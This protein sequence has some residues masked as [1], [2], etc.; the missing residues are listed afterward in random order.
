MMVDVDAGRFDETDFMC[1]PAFEFNR[2]H[3]LHQ[4][5]IARELVTFNMIWGSLES[6]AKLAKAPR[7]PKALCTSPSQID[8]ILYALKLAGDH[9]AMM[10]LYRE[11]IGTL[12]ASLQRSSLRQS[13]R[14]NATI[15]AQPHIGWEGFG[16]HIVRKVRNSFA[17]GATALDFDQETT[18]PPL[19]LVI[20]LSSRIALL[21]QQAMLLALTDEALTLRVYHGMRTY[22]P[23]HGETLMAAARA[24]HVEEPDH[25]EDQMW[26]WT[27]LDPEVR[28]ELDFDF[29]G[30]WV[31]GADTVSHHSPTPHQA[32]AS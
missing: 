19:A 14:L 9:V 3:S 6:A 4:S 22:V 18:V 8:R 20:H 15:A 13:Y 1:R 25:D 10:P 30:E 31:S 26:L 21:A 5:L 2:R 28:R 12:I 16:L 7:V 32:V 24:L 27:A 23:W 29:C 17:H 11:L